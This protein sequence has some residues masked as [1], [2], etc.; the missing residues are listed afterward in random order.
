MRELFLNDRMILVNSQH[1]P[2]QF[3]KLDKSAEPDDGTEFRLLICETDRMTPIFYD[4]SEKPYRTR[5]RIP[6]SKLAPPGNF[7]RLS[8]S[9]PA[10]TL[11]P[12]EKITHKVRGITQ[13]TEHRCRD[14]RASPAGR[15][16][17]GSGAQAGLGHFQ[18]IGEY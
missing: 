5:D 9:P 6:L 16:P 17:F 11:L 2:A 10:S 4:R 18:E 1:S 14:N 12:Y 8:R 7:T 3:T 13:G 15:K